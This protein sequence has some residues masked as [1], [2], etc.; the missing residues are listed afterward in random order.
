MRWKILR[1]Y[2]EQALELS[3]ASND[4]FRLLIHFANSLDQDQH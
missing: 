2:D 4:C 3:F 1:L